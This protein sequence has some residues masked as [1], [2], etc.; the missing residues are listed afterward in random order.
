MSAP[1]NALIAS[2]NCVESHL[3]EP[4]SVAEMAAAAGYSIFHFERLFNKNTHH[5]PYDYLI[6]R[7]LSASVQ[8][9]TQTKRRIT[10]IA[11][12]YQ[13]QNLETYSRAFRRMFNMQPS[14]CRAQ[15]SLDPRFLLRPRTLAHLQNI[16]QGDFLHPDLSPHPRRSLAGWMT[17]LTNPEQTHELLSIL[18]AAMPNAPAWYGVNLYPQDWTKT[19]AFYLAA[20]ET[21]TTDALLPTFVRYNLPGGIYATFKHPSD[22]ANLPITRDYAC[23]TWLPRTGKAIH[24]HFDLEIHRP[25]GCQ[26]LLKVQE[27]GKQ[28]EEQN[29]S[30]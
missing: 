24:S 12:D 8:E 30:G 17:R 3:R 20:V 19:G 21:P 1:L 7:R 27:T 5:T 25:N 16:S 26:Y 6:R 4:L 18:R 28:A 13:F 14:Q 29:D 10:D 23:Q 22:P 9:L 11:A 15:K 2:L